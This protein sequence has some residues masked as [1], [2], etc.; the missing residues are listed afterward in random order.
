MTRPKTPPQIKA[1]EKLYKALYKRFDG[2]RNERIYVEI[3]PDY[4][5]FRTPT[6][7]APSE[8]LLEYKQI[9]A[10]LN[11]RKFF[12]GIPVYIQG[13]GMFEIGTESLTIWNHEKTNNPA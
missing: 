3:K 7:I 12:T 9:V 1:P 8:C 10:Y 5:G 4:I 2:I 6:H 11:E 13:Y